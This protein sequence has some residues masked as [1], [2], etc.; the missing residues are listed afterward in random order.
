[1]EALINALDRVNQL[2]LPIILF[3]AGLPKVLRIFGEV[4]TYAERLFKFVSV[5]ELAEEDSREAIEKPA[6]DFGVKYTEDALKE[7][8]RWSKGYPYFIQELCSVIWEYTENE[9]ISE[10]DVEHVIPIFLKSLDE[11]FFKVRYERCTKKRA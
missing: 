11:G 9:T 6:N 4:K 3:G 2:R 5:A 10:T 1:M 7:I 8:L